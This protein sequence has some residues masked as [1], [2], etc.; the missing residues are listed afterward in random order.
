VA[1][2]SLGGS[3]SHKELDGVF[4]DSDASA[5]KPAAKLSLDGD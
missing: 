4:A 1:P 5:G 3:S 2:R